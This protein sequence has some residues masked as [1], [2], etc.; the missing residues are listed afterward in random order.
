MNK[1]FNELVATMPGLLQS[2]QSQP[3]RTR[4]NLAGIPERGVYVFYENAKALYVG[5]SNRLKARIQEHGREGSHNSAPFAFNL[6][7]E[8]MRA[9]E[10]PHYVTRKELGASPRFRGGFF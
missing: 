3:F 5:R 7:K 8:K 9:K 10:I 2:L 4:E 1:S 6:A